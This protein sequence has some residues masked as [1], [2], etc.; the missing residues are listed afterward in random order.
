MRGAAGGMALLL[1][2]WYF[3]FPME[4]SDTVMGNSGRKKLTLA[5]GETYSWPWRPEKEGTC[6]VT[7]RLSGTQ[8]AQ[9][10]TVYASVTDEA[11]TE[12]ATVV[13]PVAE[14][15]PEEENIRL[16][17]QFEKGKTYLI[18]LRAEGEGALKVRGEESEETGEFFPGL[19]EDAVYGFRNPVLLYFA[20]GAL[21]AA[22]TPVTGSWDRKKKAVPGER[23]SFSERAFP[24]AAFILIAGLGLVVALGK[25]AFD[26]GSSWQGWDEEIHWGNVEA[27]SLFAPG[28]IR[29]LGGRMITWNPGYLPLAAGYNLARIFTEKTEILYHAAA[30]CSVLVYA[31]MCALAVKHAPRY[32]MTFLAAATIP[33][34]FFLMTSATYDTVVAGSLLL[35]MALVLESC[36]EKGRI[37]PARAVLMLSLLSFGTVAKPAYS[38]GLL[39]LLM[40]P[41]DH[42]GSPQ[43]AWLFRGYVLL[44]LGWCAASMTLGAYE[45]VIAGDERFPGASVAGQ[46]EYM[47]SHP[48]E[49]GLLPLRYV[50]EHWEL[51]GRMGLSHWAHL[52]NNDRLNLIYFWLLLAAAPICTAGEKKTGKSLLTPGRRVA[53]AA[54]AMGAEILLSYAQYLA[55]T[56][57]GAGTVTGMQARYFMPVW[58]CMALALMWPQAIRSRLGKL[59]TWASGIVFLICLGG[60]LYNAMMWMQA[61][62]LW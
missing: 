8:K 21:L 53:L 59:G 32:K 16:T 61:T 40:I 25:P 22:L 57:V 56:E 50:F 52:G 54:I 2:L 15:Q 44:M 4:N 47:R 35:G 28:G 60:N 14:M 62:G 31:L 12:I 37:S 26:P 41:A 55:S 51:L 5:P 30:A 9:E 19:T 38:L 29:E 45:P 48:A 18:R 34:F 10:M 58:I 42:F 7:L 1:V 13:Q 36:E 20:A 43:K 24:W 17:G 27:M 39:A 33:T 11:E 6:A 49:G 46:L 3:L 23:G